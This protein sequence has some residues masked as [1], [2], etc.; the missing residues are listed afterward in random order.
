MGIDRSLAVGVG[1]RLEVLGNTEIA[2]HGHDLLNLTVP[3]LIVLVT[4]CIV[5]QVV[6]DVPTNR[7][8]LLPTNNKT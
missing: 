3:S 8:H 1:R 2:V 7:L 6:I 5:S 4:G